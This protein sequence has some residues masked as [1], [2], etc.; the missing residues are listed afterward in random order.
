[1]EKKENEK[2]KSENYGN[3]IGPI[4]NYFKNFSLNDYN[5][6]VKKENKKKFNIRRKSKRRK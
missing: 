1:M 6:E 2:D 4:F 5:N 3:F